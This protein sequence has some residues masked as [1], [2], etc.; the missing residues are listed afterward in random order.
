MKSSYF[1]QE[2]RGW[3]LECNN[4]LVEYKSP[5]DIP[6]IKAKAKY[7]G[8]ALLGHVGHINPYRVDFQIWRGREGGEWEKKRR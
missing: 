4:K 2:A 8:A 7:E 1:C 3:Q 6:L 5:E